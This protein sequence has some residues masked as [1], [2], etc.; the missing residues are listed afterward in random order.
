MYGHGFLIVRKP[1]QAKA[2]ASTRTSALPKCVS[3]RAQPT[4]QASAGWRR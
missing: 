3:E 4:T 2:E 1:V